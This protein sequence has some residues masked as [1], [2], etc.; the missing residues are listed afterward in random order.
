MRFLSRFYLN[1][2]NTFGKHK[3]SGLVFVE[4]EYNEV[5]NINIL[6]RDLLSDEVEQIGT[7]LN[8]TTE[9]NG[10]GIPG[11]YARLSYAGRFNYW[12]YSPSQSSWTSFALD[13]SGGS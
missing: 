12:C 3:V 2:D 8:E 4:N 6:R 5:D 1:F 9:I 7:S 13:G 10:R 11:E